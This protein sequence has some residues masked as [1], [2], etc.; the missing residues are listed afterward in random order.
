MLNYPHQWSGFDLNRHLQLKLCRRQ[1]TLTQHQLPANCRQSQCKPKGGVS[2]SGPS[3]GRETN[4]TGQTSP[5]STSRSL[6]QG[7]MFVGANFQRLSCIDVAV[8]T[9]ALVGVN[10][11]AYGSSTAIDDVSTDNTR[12]S[13]HG[14]SAPAGRGS[15]IILACGRIRWLLEWSDRRLISIWFPH[16]VPPGPLLYGAGTVLWAKRLTERGR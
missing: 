5:P 6:H 11:G 12:L 3:A 2:V 13:N 1:S 16:A 4:A 15:E 10:P 7:Q 9:T 8:E 14:C